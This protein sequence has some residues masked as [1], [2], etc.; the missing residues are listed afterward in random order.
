MRLL[1]TENK[2]GCWRDMEWGDGLNGQGTLRRVLVG[3]S[4]VLYVGDESLDSTP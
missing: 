3:M 2:Q 4:G 1:S